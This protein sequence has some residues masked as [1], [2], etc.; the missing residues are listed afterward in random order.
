MD[1]IQ[2]IVGSALGSLAHFQVLAIAAA[3][4]LLMR[5]YDQIPL[6]TLGALAVNQLVNIIR[7]LVNDAPFESTVNG[8]W[9]GFLRLDM[10]TFLIAFIAFAI[11]I[12]VVFATKTMVAHRK[13]H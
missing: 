4:G 5:K 3:A 2:D 12:A 8:K 13:A 6:I 11:V 9:N 7:A 1:S 10:Q